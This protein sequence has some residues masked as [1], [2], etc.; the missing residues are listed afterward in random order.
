MGG[1]ICPPPVGVILRPPPVRV[2]KEIIHLQKIVIM[3]V[4]NPAMPFPLIL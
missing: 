3:F 2:L 4:L 1:I